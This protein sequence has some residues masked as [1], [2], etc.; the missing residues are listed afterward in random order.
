MQG[1]V[2]VVRMNH[3]RH[4]VTRAVWTDQGLGGG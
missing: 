4:A 1:R 2:T 3:G